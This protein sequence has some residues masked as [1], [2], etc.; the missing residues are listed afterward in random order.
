MD[1]TDLKTIAFDHAGGVNNGGRLSNGKAKIKKN[2]A[3]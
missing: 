3:K 1:S 2:P